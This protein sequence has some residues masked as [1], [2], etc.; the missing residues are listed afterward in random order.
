MLFGAILALL[1]WFFGLWAEWEVP[2]DR[3]SYSWAFVQGR[4]IPGIV[5]R[6]I[7]LPIGIGLFVLGVLFSLSDL[8][9]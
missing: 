6:R 5:A 7:G 2:E 8:I 3:S 1:S 9:T 4:R